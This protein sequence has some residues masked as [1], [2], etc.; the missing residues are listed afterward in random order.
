MYLHIPFAM[1]NDI[2]QCLSSLATSAVGV[3]F[4]ISGYYYCNGVT[5]KA[6]LKIFRIFIASLL[7]F[8]WNAFL[9]SQ[10]DG[11]SLI[12]FFLQSYGTKTI[13]N[14]VLLNVPL[15]GGHL[16]YLLSILYVL[17]ICYFIPV[18]IQDKLIYRPIF[19]FF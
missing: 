19:V 9:F 14:F 7:Y 10:K 6:I 16:W 3:F 11:N 18:R 2:G 1:N 13:V 17:L 5:K 15:F 12:D 8:V 4:V